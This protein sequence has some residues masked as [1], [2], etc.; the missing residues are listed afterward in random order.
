MNLPSWMWFERR[1]ISLDPARLYASSRIGL[2][3]MHTPALICPLSLV[4]V[5]CPCISTR[6]PL[7]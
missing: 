6:Y 1:V 2:R 3:M 4:L 5:E 7:M